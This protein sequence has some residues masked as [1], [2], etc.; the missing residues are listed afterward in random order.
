MQHTSHL[1]WPGYALDWSNRSLR[2]GVGS[3]MTSTD[4]KI[5]IL[6]QRQE[7]ETI[8]ESDHSYPITKLKWSPQT[9]GP[10]L[11]ATT[12]DYFRLWEL[13]IPDDGEINGQVPLVCKAT[14][15]NV[16]KVG[17]QSKEYSAPLTSFDWNK[18]D[19]SMCVTCSIDTTCTVW[20]INTLQAKT[21]LIAHD[22]EVFDV[23]FS[24]GTHVFGSVGQDGS[25][26]MFDLRSLEHSTILYESSTDK[27]Q[28]L[29]RIGWNQQDPNYLATFQQD[30]NSLVILDTRVPAIPVTELIGHDAPL[31][32]FQWAPHSSTHILTGGDDGQAL[33]WDISNMG[34]Q[35]HIREPLLAY[36]NT[37]EIHNCS[38][39]QYSPDWVCLTSKT[40]VQSLRI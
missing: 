7:L 17:G 27:Q 36:T 33:V 2:V 35:K 12:G 9:T 24:K 15:A 26:R 32:C 13:V 29:L 34:K 16:R 8:A 1:P 21:Q 22:K 3:F 20:D 18:E 10:D 5:R 11:F 23:C 31:S 40:R 38:W 14:L 25:V 39:S 28:A 19:P 4:N 30:S 6:Q 37:D